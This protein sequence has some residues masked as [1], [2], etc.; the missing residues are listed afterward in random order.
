MRSHLNNVRLRAASNS[1][2]ALNY[3][4]DKCGKFRIQNNCFL[5]FW[6]SILICWNSLHNSHLLRFSILNSRVLP[7]SFIGVGVLWRENFQMGSEAIIARFSASTATP[8]C[9]PMSIG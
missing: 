2:I 1:L 5:I 4:W 7:V 8:L 3:Y 6:N 9:T